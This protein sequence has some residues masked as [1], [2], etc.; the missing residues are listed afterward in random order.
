MQKMP[1]K[2]KTAETRRLLSGASCNMQR[3]RILRECVALS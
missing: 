1:K 2:K 3:V